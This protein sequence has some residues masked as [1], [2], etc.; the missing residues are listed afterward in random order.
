MT[1]E[2]YTRAH[3]P[4]VESLHP[5]GDP[6]QDHLIDE[7]QHPELVDGF[8]ALAPHEPAPEPEAAV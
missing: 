3:S 6:E 8:Q 7:V 1:D 5:T 2:Q 4:A